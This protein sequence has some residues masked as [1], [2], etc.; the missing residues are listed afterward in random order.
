MVEGLPALAEV[1]GKSTGELPGFDTGRAGRVLL[2]TADGCYSLHL[3]TWEL[4]SLRINDEY[5]DCG[6]P[7][8]VYH[9]VAFQTST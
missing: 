8:F 5:V 6:D 9:S 3:D 4:E 1:P 2:Q 7:V